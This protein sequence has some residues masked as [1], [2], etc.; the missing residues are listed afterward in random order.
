MLYYPSKTYCVKLLHH[1]LD[2]LVIVSLGN[3]CDVTSGQTPITGV[4]V[5]A[6]EHR[7]RTESKLAMLF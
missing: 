3:Y 7:R 1:L 2:V 6:L 4:Y 5:S